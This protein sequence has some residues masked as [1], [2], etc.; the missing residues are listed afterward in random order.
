M[1]AGRGVH[2][3][4]HAPH[5]VQTESDVSISLSVTF[6]TRSSKFRESIH[7]ANSHVRKLGMRPPNPGASR[8]WDIAAN[9]G[10]RGFYKARKIANRLGG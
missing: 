8:M 4:L 1:L 3:P 6:R 7:A 2:F 5:W 9:V 10:Y